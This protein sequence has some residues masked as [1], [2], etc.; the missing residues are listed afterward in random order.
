MPPPVPPS[1]FSP[2]SPHTPPVSPHSPLSAAAAS[3]ALQSC[4]PGKPEP[5]SQRVQSQTDAGFWGHQVGSSS[6]NAGAG[7]C[8]AQGRCQGPGKPR[9]GRAQTGSAHTGWG[10]HHHRSVRS[11]REPWLS[12]PTHILGEEETTNFNFLV[13][14]NPG[15]HRDHR[16]KTAGKRKYRSAFWIQGGSECPPSWPHLSG[17]PVPSSYLVSDPGHSPSA[18]TSHSSLWAPL[19]TQTLV[20]GDSILPQGLLKH[21]FEQGHVG[22]VLVLGH[23]PSGHH[24]HHFLMQ[25]CLDLWVLRKMVQGPCQRVGCLGSTA[26]DEVSRDF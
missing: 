22:K 8:Q 15:I 19:H 2:P 25:G 11:P 26:R 6:A 7:S 4:G 21:S 12:S 5:H 20:P 17:P 16:I 3:P 14:D 13:H 1:P 23:L 9:S 18:S 10:V 24:T